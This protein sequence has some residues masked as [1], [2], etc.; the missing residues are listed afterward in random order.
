MTSLF[1]DTHLP[2]NRTYL[3]ARARIQSCTVWT[4]DG[5]SDRE[6]TIAE[7][8]R[9]ASGALSR[10][11]DEAWRGADADGEERGSEDEPWMQQ[12]KAALDIE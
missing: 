5:G 12:G 4:A 2:K 10:S 7:E 6:V 8:E 1:D 3:Y 9:A 11:Q